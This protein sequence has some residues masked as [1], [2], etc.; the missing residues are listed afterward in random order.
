MD[1][2]SDQTLANVTKETV[3]SPR[4]TK[5]VISHPHCSEVYFVKNVFK[6][7]M[8]HLYHKI[9]FIYQNS[10]FKKYSITDKL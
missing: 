7:I 5:L 8:L 3:L 4:I 6:S 9:P 10:C 1:K 2:G